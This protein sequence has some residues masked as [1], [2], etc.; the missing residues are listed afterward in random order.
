MPFLP[1]ERLDLLAL[2]KENKT[3]AALPLTETELDFFEDLDNLRQLQ[4]KLIINPPKLGRVVE[5]ANIILLIDEDFQFYETIEQIVKM[6]QPPYRILVD[7]SFLLEN[8][9][10]EDLALRQMST[11]LPIEPNLIRDADAK[12]T[13]LSNLPDWSDLPRMV[14]RAHQ[15]QSNFQ[16]SGYNMTKLLTCSV[17]LTKIE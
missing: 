12:K 16:Q 17:F 2:V 5:T 7:F 1:F 9:H 3:D 4:T 8:F 15:N 13:F 11:S 14:E 6:I 10:I